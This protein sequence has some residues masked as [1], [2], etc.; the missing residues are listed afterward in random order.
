MHNQQNAMCLHT[1]S[2]HPVR[3]AGNCA[4][5]PLPFLENP[6]DD[7]CRYAAS[8]CLPDKPSVG[9]EFGGER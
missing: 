9:G 7:C 4:G 2:L 1:P 5:D 8:G 3:I 6:T